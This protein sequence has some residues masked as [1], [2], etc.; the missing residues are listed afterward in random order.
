MR[1]LVSTLPAWAGSRAQ[2]AAVIGALGAAAV[3]LGASATGSSTPFDGKWI[4]DATA[5]G[6]LCPVRSKRL[7][8]LVTS[9]RFTKIVGLPSPQTSGFVDSSGA[10][11]IEIKTLG[12]TAHVK[13]NLVGKTGQGEW[14]SNSFLCPG[15]G[16]RAAAAAGER[17]HG[18]VRPAKPARPAPA[19]ASPISSPIY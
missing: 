13:G 5:T 14:S 6:A 15:G 3:A 12:V 2:M 11:T 18:P 8:A 10:V 16:W 9:G 7:G 4:I 17:P 19:S 1:G